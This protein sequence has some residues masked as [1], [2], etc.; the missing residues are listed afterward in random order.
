M[1]VRYIFLFVTKNNTIGIVKILI[2][3]VTIIADG[4]F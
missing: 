1:K 2:T 4:V 3:V